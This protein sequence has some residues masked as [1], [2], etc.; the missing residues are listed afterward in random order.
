MAT[1]YTD[2]S[3]GV[4]NI[5]E[6]TDNAGAAA[7]DVSAEEDRF[8]Q[9]VLSEGIVSPLN[10][11][12]PAAGTGWGV[13]IGSGGSKTD[14][15][16]VGGDA[17][18]QGNYLVRLP[19]DATV[20]INAADPSLDRIDEVYLVVQDNA[21]DS[22]S[23]AL[24]RL[25]YRD[26]TAAAS[27]VAPGPDGTWQAYVKLATIDVP[28]GAA[29]AAGCTITDTRPRSGLS[30]GGSERLGTDLTDNTVVKAPSGKEARLAV[31]GA[32]KV[33]ATSSGATVTGNLDVTGTVDGVDLSAHTHD[34]LDGSAVISHADLA[35]LAVGDPHPQYT[36][37]AD[38]Q[39]IVIGE[40]IDATTLDGIDS[41]GF[42]LA[43]HNHDSAYLGLTAT[44]AAATKLATARTITLSGDVTGSTTFDG[45]A[46]KTITTTVA[47]D[48]HTHD[49]RYY[50]ESEA[51]GRYY[52]PSSSAGRKVTISTSGPSGGSNGDL[53]FEY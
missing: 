1:T 19:S 36:T 25:A 3:F 27:P 42:A 49:S 34:G 20:T 11:F 52:G 22:S 41:T 44:A 4:R 17:A 35:D 50:T 13:D 5:G 16:V 31:G 10:A 43:G 51:N 48:S 47:N 30:F 21:Y 45:A 26:G 9:V 14:Y 37:Q 29:N 32:T 8:S 40:N 23:R 46:N 28:A 53:W 7:T 6:R 24:P 33:A 2:A 18:G 15:A 38:V 12:L 39:S